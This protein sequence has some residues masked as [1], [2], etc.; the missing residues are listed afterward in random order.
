M[1]DLNR[2]VAEW[3]EIFGKT[4]SPG[5]PEEA[6]ASRVIGDLW[7][8]RHASKHRAQDVKSLAAAF[9]AYAKLIQEHGVKL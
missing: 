7:G 3:T 1:A 9:E 5:S 4:P 6:I 2:T 8:Y